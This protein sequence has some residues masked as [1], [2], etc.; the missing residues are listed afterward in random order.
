MKAILISIC[1]VITFTTVCLADPYS[2]CSVYGNCKVSSTTINT[3]NNNTITVNQSQW[4]QG[5]NSSDFVKKPTDNTTQL[6]IMNDL[7][8]NTIHSELGSGDGTRVYLDSDMVPSFDRIY[9]LGN[10][11]LDTLTF[12]AYKAIYVNTTYTDNLEALENGLNIRNTFNTHSFAPTS[13]DDNLYEVGYD[14]GVTQLRYSNGHFVKVITDAICSGVN[15]TGSVIGCYNLTDLNATGSSGGNPFN[16]VLNTTNDV[17]FHEINLSNGSEE[18]L[19]SVADAGSVITFNPKAG[20]RVWDGT[21]WGT[22]QSASTIDGYLPGANGE[23][24]G[25]N[26][27]RIN[28]YSPNDLVLATGGGNVSAQGFSLQTN[29]LFIN[30]P[31]S[32]SLKQSMVVAQTNAEL[33]NTLYTATTDP[34]LFYN[35]GGAITLKTISAS[36]TAGAG[37]ALVGTRAKGTSAIPLAVADGDTIFSMS[38][39]GYRGVGTAQVASMVMLINGT[40]NATATPGRILF[41]TTNFRGL[42]TDAGYIDSNQNL[43]W[44]KN[45][46]FNGTMLILDSVN[47]TGITNIS[48]NLYVSNNLTA[49]RLDVTGNATIIGNL[50]VTQGLTSTGYSVNALAGLSSNYTVMKTALT[51]CDLNFTKGLLTAS[52]C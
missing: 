20:V 13:P 29:R 42:I 8:V 28:Y 40:V 44:Y 37:T 48:N 9:S 26:T 43:I 12:L 39:L 27:M 5:F 36:N 3:F 19:V 21:S 45:S 34:V 2:D 25:W 6:T 33:N 18:G 30:V 15:V 10:F 50:N 22:W 24:A 38:G 11:S 14:D 31:A 4:L 47:I 49:K 46:L 52:S 51:T 41:R 7:G 17:T 1:L 32:T 16:Q 35:S 23:W